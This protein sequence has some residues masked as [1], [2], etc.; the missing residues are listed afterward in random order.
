MVEE[1]RRPQSAEIRRVGNSG[2]G[3]GLERN[4]CGSSKS[5]TYL[6]STFDSIMCDGLKKQR[7]QLSLARDVN[8]Y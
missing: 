8:E 3:S 1:V 7:C 5:I 2:N 4:C 6:R